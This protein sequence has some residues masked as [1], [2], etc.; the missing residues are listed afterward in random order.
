MAR[1][2]RPTRYKDQN[3]KSDEA[4]SKRNINQSTMPP[5]CMSWNRHMNPLNAF[6]S[7]LCCFFSFHSEENKVLQIVHMNWAEHTS[8]YLRTMQPNTAKNA[9]Q[10]S[11][12]I[13]RPANPA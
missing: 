9:V 7:L 11:N 1:S 10:P 8:E 3:P 13:T 6:T 12:R 5:L 4:C 2:Q